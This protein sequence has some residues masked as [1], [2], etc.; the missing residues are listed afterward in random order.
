[1]GSID[2][3]RLWSVFCI[4]Q[5]VWFAWRERGARLWLQRFSAVA[6]PAQRFGMSCRIPA[7]SIFQLS[8]K[9]SSR[10][11]LM[12]VFRWFRLQLCFQA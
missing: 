3:I 5:F 10:E 4:G 2:F 12:V 11:S 9:H 7:M 8:P 1:M 6:R